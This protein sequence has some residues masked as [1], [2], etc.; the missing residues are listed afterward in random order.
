[1][2]FLVQDIPPNPPADSLVGQVDQ[3]I[4]ILETLY[5]ELVSFVVA[6]GFQILGGV[7]LL[8]IGVWLSNKIFNFVLTICE[9]RHLDI[10]LS[11][12]IASVVRIAA[13]TFVIIVVLHQ[14]GI[15]IT[16]FI[17][18]IGAGAFGLSLAIQAPISNYGAGLSLILTR[19][20]KV[21]DTITVLGRAGIVQD[22]KL[23]YTVLHTEDEEV[24]SLPNRHVVGEIFENTYKNTLID[25]RIGIPYAT[26]PET[27]IA[28]IKQT[29]R[30]IEGIDSSPNPLVGIHAFG[31]SS[32]DIGF[33]CWA[34]TLRYHELRYA[35]NLALFK[36]LKNKG[37]EVPFPQ[38][39]IRV[40]GDAASGAGL[41]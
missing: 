29:I 14:F 31:D 7:V 18:A 1:M 25:G 34:P 17:A 20:F 37:I 8:A 9:R 30:S 26:D 39:E 5:K 12:F 28:V 32:I 33:R 38:R 3:S 21:G 41:S 19:P 10:T 40:L 36:A 13:L 4:E 22:I 27:A 6:Y 24:I 15:T 16:P 11:K 2:R 35:V 23:A